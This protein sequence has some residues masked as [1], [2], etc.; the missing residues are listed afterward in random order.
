MSIDE[1][2]LRGRLVVGMIAWTT[3]TTPLTP[4]EAAASGQ[5]GGLSPEP[6]VKNPTLR[7]ELCVADEP[8]GLVDGVTTGW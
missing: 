7:G 5:D 6:D 2:V 1:P 8:N 4:T 3:H